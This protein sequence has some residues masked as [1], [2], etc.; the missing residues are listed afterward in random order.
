VLAG[1]ICPRFY[2]LEKENAYHQSIKVG[3]SARNGL[4]KQLVLSIAVLGLKKSGTDINRNCYLQG[5]QGKHKSTW[6]CH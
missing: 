1:D 4:L 2:C 5:F 6:R 3:A